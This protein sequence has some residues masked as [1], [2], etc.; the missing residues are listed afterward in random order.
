MEKLELVFIEKERNLYKKMYHKLEE[1]LRNKDLT[2][3][4]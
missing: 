2:I 1:A 4:D 3:H